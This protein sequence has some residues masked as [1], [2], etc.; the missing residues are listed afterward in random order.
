MHSR[1]NTLYP[2]M[3]ERLL[4]ARR[5]EFSGATEPPGRTRGAL[6]I[7]LDARRARQA[8]PAG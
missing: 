4:R 3:N 1:L 2:L 5:A 6:R 8:N 7:T